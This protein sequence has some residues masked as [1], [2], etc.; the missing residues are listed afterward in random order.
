VRVP[1]SDGAVAVLAYELA[2]L[3]RATPFD[4]FGQLAV[5][6]VDGR[7]WLAD[8]PAAAKARRALRLQRPRHP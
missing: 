3:G 4:Y 8:A 6:L 2:S 5:A 7:W 1:R